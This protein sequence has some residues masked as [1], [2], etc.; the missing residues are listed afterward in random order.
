[1]SRKTLVF[2]CVILGLLVFLGG[3]PVRVPLARFEDQALDEDRYVCQKNIAIGKMGR[4][5]G[6]I[7]LT[8]WSGHY[9][10]E[11]LFMTM[12]GFAA[13]DGGESFNAWHRS[14]YKEGRYYFEFEGVAPGNYA[15]VVDNTDRGWEDTDFDFVNDYAVFD[16]EV[17]FQPY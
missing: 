8:H 13:Y 3:C 2:V 6:R 14:V 9:G 11:I 16:L 4:V 17:Y 15:L 12:D 1:M 10:L 5:Y 7:N